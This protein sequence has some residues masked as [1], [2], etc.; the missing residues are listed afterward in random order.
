MVAGIPGVKPYM[1]DIFMAG[2]SKQEHDRN[3]HAVLER[4]R[5]Y[6][7]HLRL[8]KCRFVLSQI[9]FLGHIVDKDGIR[10]DPS[11]TMMQPPKDVQQLRSYLGA[12]N[13]YGLFVKQM[14][15]LRAPLDNLLK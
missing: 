14:K 6:G 13:Y 11:K 7:F 5:E 4:I 3:L 12:V 1:N 15:K 2:H 8:E 10:P 9:E